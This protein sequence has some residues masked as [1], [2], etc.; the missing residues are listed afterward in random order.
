ML[1]FNMHYVSTKVLNAILANSFILSR[2]YAILIFGVFRLLKISKCL[3]YGSPLTQFDRDRS[4]CSK[5]DY[6]PAV[7]TG[8]SNTRFFPQFFLFF[9]FGRHLP[10]LLVFA[11]PNRYWSQ[12]PAKYKHCSVVY[13]RFTKIF[14]KVGVENY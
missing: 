3:L 14:M 8:S 9:F 7:R 11:W 10:Q 13:C 2:I 1:H 6:Y 12:T 5:Q 4:Y